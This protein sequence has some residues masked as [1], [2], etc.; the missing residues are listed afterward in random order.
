MP[1]RKEYTPGFI[2]Q[3]VRFALEEIVTDESR[4]H[5]CERLAPRLSVKAMTQDNLVKRSAPGTARR[6]A[7]PG[8]KPVHMR[9][10]S[11]VLLLYLRPGH[12]CHEGVGFR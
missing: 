5:A 1:S 6:L 3:A 9:G 12:E 8:L 11:S 10:G 7:S 4:K 2:D